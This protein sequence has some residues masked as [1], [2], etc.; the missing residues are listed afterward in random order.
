MKLL[1]ALIIA[2]LL[3]AVNQASAQYTVGI[4]GG[5]TVA[6]PDYGDVQL[7]ENAET[8]VNGLNGSLLIY[9]RAH[10]HIHVGFEPGYINRGAACVPGWQPIFVGDTKLLLNYVELPLMISGNHSLIDNRLE[11]FG[12]LGYGL[13]MITTAFQEQIPQN[14]EIPPSRDRLDVDDPSSSLNRFDHGLYGG[15]GVA[16]NFDVYQ[17]FVE[18]NYYHGMKDVDKSTTSKIRSMNL[19]VGCAIK[20]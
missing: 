16:Y 6:W 2:T 17:V 5:Y 10:D 11:V 1:Q 3:F 20:L 14:T 18:T 13:S 15:I 4:K 8:Q 7:P 9:Y 19:S 12:K